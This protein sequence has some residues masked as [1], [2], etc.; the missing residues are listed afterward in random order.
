MHHDIA[1]VHTVEALVGTFEELI[2]QI[3][4]ELA[5]RHVVDTSLLEDALAAGWVDDALSERIRLAMCK[6]A[7]T[8]ARVEACTCSTI[9]GAAEQAGEGRGFVSMRIDRAM[10]DEAVRLGPRVL[11]TASVRSTLEPTRQLIMD[12]AARLGSTVTITDL[13]V[14]HAWPFCESGDT[15]AYWQAIADALQTDPN[16]VDVIVLAQASMAGAAQRCADLSVP[17]LSS[18]RLGVE[19]KR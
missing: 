4:P 5:V 14:D 17:V 18:P 11:L 10:A 8:G 16:D 2:A 13:L 3:G 15:D 6:A 19:S 9:G 12:S 1:F 7:Q